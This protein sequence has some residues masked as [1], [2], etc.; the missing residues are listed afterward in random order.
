MATQVS[1]VLYNRHQVL[2]GNEGTS[3][4][5]SKVESIGTFASGPQWIDFCQ[6]L[7]EVYRSE[8]VRDADRGTG[9]AAP[10]GRVAQFRRVVRLRE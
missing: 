4:C 2:H 9:V 1:V 8:P 7:A 6:Q 10:V 5:R 3:N